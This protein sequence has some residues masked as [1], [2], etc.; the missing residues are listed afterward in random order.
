MKNK[1]K[2]I[3]YIDEKQDARVVGPPGPSKQITKG[4]LK[5]YKTC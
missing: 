3:L 4:S 1:I 2:S 5:R